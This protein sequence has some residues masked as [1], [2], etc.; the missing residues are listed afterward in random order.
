MRICVECNAD[1]VLMRT[2]GFS[3]IVHQR[4]KSKV[5][6][7]VRKYEGV[8]GLED[9]DPHTIRSRGI[10]DFT[11][12][13]REHEVATLKWGERKI[14]LLSPRLEDWILRTAREEKIDVRK[15][16][17]RLPDDGNHLHKVINSNLDGFE[18]LVKDLRKSKRMRT[19]VQRTKE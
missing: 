15:D 2:L 11:E 12:I 4:G 13:S 6:L 5:T 9:E 10:Q 19:L 1:T 18:Q 7:Y 8:V 17:Y 14:I 3:E 16:R